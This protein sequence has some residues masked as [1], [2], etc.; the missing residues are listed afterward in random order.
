MSLGVLGPLG[1]YLNRLYVSK[2]VIG[3]PLTP[4]DPLNDDMSL[5]VLAPLGTF[6][7]FICVKGGHRVTY[8]PL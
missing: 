1:T 4:F 7:S 2:G 5:G 8:D 3:Q 6:E